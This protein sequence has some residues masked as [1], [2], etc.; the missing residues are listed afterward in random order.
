MLH[1]QSPVNRKE[2]IMKILICAVVA[3]LLAVPSMLWAEDAP[4]EEKPAEAKKPVYDE[5]ADAKVQLETAL[6]AAKKEN[7]RVLIQWGGN[8]CSWCVLLHDRFKSDPELAKKLHYEYDVVFIDIGKNDKNL[9]LAEK[10]SADLK[11]GVPYLT[12]LDA[13]GK[14]LTNQPTDPFETKDGD[15]K[16]HDPK[17]LL[18]FLK[19]HQATPLKAE[20]VLSAALAVAAKEERKVFLHF[21]A[22]WCGW[23]LRLDAWLAR[24]EV[25]KVFGKD[26]AEVKIDMDRME[27]AKEVFGRYNASNKGGIPWF[28]ILDAKGKSLI[29]SDG[30][31]GK[32][33]GFPAE[34]QEIAHFAKMLEATKQR[35]TEQERAELCKSLKDL[36]AARK[37]LIQPKAQAQSQ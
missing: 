25:A 1:P 16:G 18:E 5:K 33:I 4:K 35:I 23:C 29:T 32:N 11:K 9:D 15:K 3:L 2:G 34:D 36:E 19:T 28:L 26:Y 37:A 12:V 20:E 22:P 17:K 14:V 31:D 21:G 30:P 10:Y 13:D 8:W 6:A 27:G 7:R 24:P